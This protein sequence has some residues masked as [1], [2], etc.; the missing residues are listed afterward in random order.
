MKYVYNIFSNS[1]KKKKNNHRTFGRDIILV[2]IE[3]V[4]IIP[5]GYSI[6]VGWFEY[7]ILI[8][9][10][11]ICSICIIHHKRGLR[12]VAVSKI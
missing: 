11:D 7:I 2:W 8:S 4:P 1:N 5:I 10:S 9:H 3:E 12:S 6:K